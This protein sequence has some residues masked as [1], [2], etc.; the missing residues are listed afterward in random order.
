MKKTCWTFVL[1]LLALAQLHAR[2]GESKE[3]ITRRYGE[4]KPIASSFAQCERFQYTSGGLDV[5]VYFHDGKSVH[6]RIRLED[7]KLTD[8]EIEDLL[9]KTNSEG[10]HWIVRIY[11]DKKKTKYWVCDDKK[12]EAHREGAQSKWIVIQDT[13]TLKS[14]G[15]E[16]K[17]EL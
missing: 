16:N 5:M 8:L 4:A 15:I 10:Q 7:R 1:S 13:E 11:N 17:R 9:R 2:L 14:L 6:E 12:A 3:E